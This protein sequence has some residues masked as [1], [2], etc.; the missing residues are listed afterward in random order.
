MGFANFHIHT[1]FSDGMIGPYKLA[2]AIYNQPDLNYFSITDHDTMSAIE[3]FF[4]IKETLEAE[5][6]QRIKH[7]VPE[8]N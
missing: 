1:Y 6:P 5:A 2:E 4:R 7:F 3:P 8:L